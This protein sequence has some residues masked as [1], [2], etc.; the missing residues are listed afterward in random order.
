MTNQEKKEVLAHEAE[1]ITQTVGEEGWSNFNEIQL[2][3]IFLSLDQPQ[4]IEPLRSAQQNLA[5]QAK[6]Y[7]N[8]HY[9]WDEK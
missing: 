2:W 9:G 1:D 6:A 8:H 3:H 5:N 7:G 4:L